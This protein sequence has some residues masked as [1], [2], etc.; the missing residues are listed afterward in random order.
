MQDIRLLTIS[1]EAVRITYMKNR[2]LITGGAGF[3][4]SHLVDAL[5]L[6]G[7]EVMVL[8]NL[9]TGFRKFLNPQAQLVKLDIRDKKAADFIV[10]WQPDMIYHLA[11][12]IIAPLSIENPLH[13]AEINIMGTLN[14]LE[15]ARQ[16]KVKRFVLVSSGGLL[17]SEETVLPTDEEHIIKPAIP[18]CLSKLAAED[19]V[20]FYREA[21]ALPAAIVR[22]ANV[23]GPRQNP[24]GASGV[25][26]IFAERMLK[27]QP[28][29]LD[30]DGTQTADHIYVGD[31]VRALLLLG[32][33]PEATGPYHLGTGMETSVKDIFAK[34]AE[35]TG[36]A[37]GDY[38]I[39]I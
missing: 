8:D 15:A 20:M 13:D 7:H 26:A 2:I 1:Y 22:L 29:R 36:Y 3:I 23:Y 19:Y 32:E 18:Y 5:V 21:H 34:L 28:L 16:A 35:L 24:Q 38:S 31:V 37:A 12:Q 9:S 30:G 33:R 39:V 14:I 10:K 4:G 25:V 11:A 6:R 27:R 17:S